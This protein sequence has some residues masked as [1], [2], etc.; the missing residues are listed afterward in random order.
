MENDLE[1]EARSVVWIMKKIQAYRDVS[2]EDAE[3]LC[4]VCSLLSTLLR[5]IFL[6]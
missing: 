2:A 5:L 3:N 4:V 1:T 6:I